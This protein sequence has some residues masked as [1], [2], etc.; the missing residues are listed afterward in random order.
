[1]DN[2]DFFIRKKGGQIEPLRN[3]ICNTLPKVGDVL[4]QFRS[5]QTFTVYKVKLENDRFKVYTR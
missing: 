3:I 5:S 4:R 1:M 2:V